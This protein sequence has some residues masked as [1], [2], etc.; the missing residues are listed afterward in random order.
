MVRSARRGGAGVRAGAVAASRPGDDQAAG[1]GG[2]LTASMLI[3]QRLAEERA[4]DPV[5]PDGVFGPRTRSAIRAWQ[6]AREE[7]RTGYLDA[8]QTEV[9][10]AM[11]GAAVSTDGRSSRLAAEHGHVDGRQGCQSDDEASR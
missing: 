7:F 5:S 3:Q 8:A 11:T 9:L 10:S 4:L 6:A 1:C 2:G